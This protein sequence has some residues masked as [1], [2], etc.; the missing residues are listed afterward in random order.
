VNLC[1]IRLEHVTDPRFYL[2]PGARNLII[3]H[4]QI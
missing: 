2:T 3:E 1:L 4:V